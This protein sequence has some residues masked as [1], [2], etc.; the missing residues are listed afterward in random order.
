LDSLDIVDELLDDSFVASGRV[1]RFH[2]PEGPISR[3]IE[4]NGWIEIAVDSVWIGTLPDTVIRLFAGWRHYYE[5][6]GIQ[7]G[8]RV[9]AHGIGWPRSDQPMWGNV[10]A[11]HREGSVGWF[12]D[13]GGTRFLCGSMT[14]DSSGAVACVEQALRARSSENPAEW[15]A[16]GTGLLAVR[17]EA[18]GRVLTVTDVGP[19]LGFGSTP[20]RTLTP[21]FRRPM[22][23][24]F[25]PQI[26]DTLI[27]PDRKEFAREDA[28]VD[29]CPERLMSRGSGK[30]GILGATYAEVGARLRRRPGGLEMVRIWNAPWKQAQSRTH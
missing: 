8:D 4:S 16:T 10:Y 23:C 7:P 2:T 6:R 28:I 25:A 11:V 17:I 9:I 19:S 1:L 12:H 18:I 20:L 27:L 13:P 5:E 14:S 24:G 30:V 29:V 3:E 15:L 21:R 26:G 22:S